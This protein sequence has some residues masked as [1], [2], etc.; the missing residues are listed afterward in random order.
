MTHDTAEETVA[1]RTTRH[2]AACAD[3]DGMNDDLVRIAVALRAPAIV[4]RLLDDEPHR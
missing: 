1:I 2:T 4:R 3:H